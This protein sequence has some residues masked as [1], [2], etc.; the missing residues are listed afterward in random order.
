MI[1]HWID[2]RFVAGSSGR[3]G[4]VFNPATGQVI[5]EVALASATEVGAAVASAERAAREWRSAS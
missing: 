1:S 5:D 3:A 4:P 2:G